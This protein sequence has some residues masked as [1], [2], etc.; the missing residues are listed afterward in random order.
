MKVGT[1]GVLLGAWATLDHKP[2]SILDVGSGTGLLALMLAQRSGAELI[3][4]IELDDDA[5]EQAVDNFEASPWG[6]RLFCYHA[7]LQEFASE[8]DETYDLIVCNPPFHE[9]QAAHGRGDRLEDSSRRKARFTETLPIEELIEGVSSLLSGSG[10]LALVLPANAE[11]KC[12]AVAAD[13]DLFPSRITD[14]RGHATAPVKRILLEFK[15]GKSDLTRDELVVETSRHNYTA[16]Y[17]ELT[18][19]FYLKM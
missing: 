14:V 15:K 13:F 11:E 2:E 16:E 9:T 5:Y 19:E 1:D 8:M 6:D 3:D 10:I 17:R 18:R 7:S 12:S 4:A